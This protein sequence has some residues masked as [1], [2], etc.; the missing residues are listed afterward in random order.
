MERGAKSR[1]RGR[2]Q[3]ESR[4]GEGNLVGIDA[5]GSEQLEAVGRADPVVAAA[6]ADEP[7][8]VGERPQVGVDGVVANVDAHDA[9]DHER[10]RGHLVATEVDY[11]VDAAFE[12]RR[13]LGYPRRGDELRRRPGH[14]RD[15]PLVDLGAELRARGVGVEREVLGDHRDRQL[16]CRPAVRERVLVDARPCPWPDADGGIRVEREAVEER[17]RRQVGDAVR[18]GRRDPRDRAWV[19][20]PV[21]QPVQ[22]LPLQP[23]GV[24]DHAA[25]VVLSVPTPSTVTSTTSPGTT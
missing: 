17:E 1:P 12:R 2:G 20:E 13:R 16:G 3:P 22:D 25:K 11:L 4:S 23:R 6:P 9:R 10:I 21:H 8:H 19:D 14:A 18:A 7:E 5:R 15:R 24:E